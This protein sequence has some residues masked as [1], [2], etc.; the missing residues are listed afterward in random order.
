MMERELLCSITCS[1]RR[2][3]NHNVHSCM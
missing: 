2:C 1:A 3:K